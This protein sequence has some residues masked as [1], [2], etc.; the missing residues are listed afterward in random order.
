MCV[1]AAGRVLLGPAMWGDA[2]SVWGDGGLCTGRDVM[3]EGPGR[4]MLW[5][6]IPESRALEMPLVPQPACP[7]LSSAPPPASPGTWEPLGPSPGSCLERRKGE[8]STGL[9]VP[10][11][12]FSGELQGGTFDK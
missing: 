9:K 3:Q 5:L 4:G 8:Q 6:R 1:V 12:R 7:V 11:W 2:G 10:A